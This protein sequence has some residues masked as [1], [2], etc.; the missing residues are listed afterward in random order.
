M[1]GDAG[2]EPATSTVCKRHEICVVNSINYLQTGFEH[3]L[4]KPDNLPGIMA[5]DVPEMWG[6]SNTAYGLKATN[7]QRVCQSFQALLSN[8]LGLLPRMRLTLTRRVTER[9]AEW[10]RLIL[11]AEWVDIK[12]HY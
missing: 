11:Q 1:V 3:G 10:R 12:T 8:R 2:F 4:L 5:A 9:K 7:T 6:R